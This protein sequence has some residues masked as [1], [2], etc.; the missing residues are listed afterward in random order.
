MVNGIMGSA[1]ADIIAAAKLH[2]EPGKFTTFVAYEYTSSGSD[3]GNLHRNVIFRGAARLPAMP[4]SRFNDVNPEGLWDWIDNLRE[5][6][7]E[8]LAIP[9][10]SN[11]SN[12]Q[13]FKLGDWAG[14]PMDDDYAAQRM[15]NE[16]F[17]SGGSQNAHVL[18]IN[19]L[20]LVLAEICSHGLNGPGEFNEKLVGSSYPRCQADRTCDNLAG[21]AA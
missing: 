17:G 6:G 7:I 15:R 21:I 1:W 20:G 10:N 14:N 3:R 8:S 19:T 11:G 4:F 16:P 5:Q 13:M 12:G 9:H 2:N 18:T